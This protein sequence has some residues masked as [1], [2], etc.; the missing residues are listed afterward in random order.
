MDE[1]G[2]Y[3]RCWTLARQV[4][5]QAG[6]VDALREALGDSKKALRVELAKR[7][8]A[9]VVAGTPERP[10]AAAGRSLNRM[11]HTILKGMD[12]AGAVSLCGLATWPILQVGLFLMK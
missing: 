1:V 3:S 12:P 9:A 10:G 5:E 8:S 4:A 2:G 6:V 11:D 7:P